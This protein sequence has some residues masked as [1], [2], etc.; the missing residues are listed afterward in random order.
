MMAAPR[1]RPHWLP[2]KRENHERPP[3][4]QESYRRERVEFRTTRPTTKRN[5]QIAMRCDLRLRFHHDFRGPSAVA[6]DLVFGLVDIV[7]LGKYAKGLLIMLPLNREIQ[8]VK[9]RGRQKDFFV[10]KPEIAS[11]NKIGSRRL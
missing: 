2:L 7:L 9:Q 3:T 1:C 8:A 4:S 11:L 10:T 6:S 5:T